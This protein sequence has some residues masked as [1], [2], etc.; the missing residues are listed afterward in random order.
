MDKIKRLIWPIVKEA[1]NHRWFYWKVF[2]AV[3]TV[4]IF[5]VLLTENPTTIAGA[6]FMWLI[7]LYL[8][9][10]FAGLIMVILIRI[11]RVINDR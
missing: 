2:T 3:L 9:F 7:S 1:A 4:L 10:T 8:G 6:I 5:A 11:Y